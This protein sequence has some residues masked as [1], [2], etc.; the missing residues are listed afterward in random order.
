MELPVHHITTE[1]AP[2]L[3]QGD[4]LVLSTQQSPLMISI[5]CIG[6]LLPAHGI[7]KSFL[8]FRN[9]RYFEDL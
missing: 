7:N 2:N 9:K 4:T 6:G 8:T 3:R 1:N 5:F